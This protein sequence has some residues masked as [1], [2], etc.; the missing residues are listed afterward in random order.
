MAG[1]GEAPLSG[2]GTCDPRWFLEPDGERRRNAAYHFGTAK[3]GIPKASQ[4]WGRSSGTFSVAVRPWW[5]A[6][7]QKGNFHF[8]PYILIPKHIQ[9]G[10]EVSAV[11]QCYARKILEELDRGS[12]MRQLFAPSLECP[13]S[14]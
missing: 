9:Q 10:S 12:L 11:F 6:D 5:E 2:L 3:R 13:P 1:G 7:R 4:K 8:V 14:F